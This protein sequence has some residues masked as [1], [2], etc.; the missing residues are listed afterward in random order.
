MHLKQIAFVRR[1][2][3]IVRCAIWPYIGSVPTVL[4]ELDVI[5]VRSAWRF[6]D[7][8]QFVLAAINWILIWYRPDGDRTRDEI[9]ETFIAMLENGLTPH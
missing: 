6:E 7:K 1:S 3:E 8:Y 2:A 4:S 9:V 5:A